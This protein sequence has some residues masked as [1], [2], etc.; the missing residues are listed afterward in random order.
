VGQNRTLGKSVEP[1]PHN[2]VLTWGTV[3][4]LQQRYDQGTLSACVGR[5]AVACIG[6]V[7]GIGSLLLDTHWLSDIVAGW[8]IG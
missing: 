2:G 8:A 7:V 6:A 4:W 5:A 1:L 3:P